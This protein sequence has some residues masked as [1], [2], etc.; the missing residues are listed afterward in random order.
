MFPTDFEARI[1]DIRER[2]GAGSTR[3]WLGILL[4]CG[5]A[6]ASF[7]PLPTFSKYVASFSHSFTLSTSRFYL[8]PQLE[9]N[10]ITIRLL[11][12]KMPPLLSLT[13]IQMMV[14]EG[15]SSAR[16]I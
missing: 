1:M 14:P 2:R 6:L 16:I 4:L 12:K 15:K 8:S 11:W 5:L 13:F 3:Q 9:T 7:E 10:V